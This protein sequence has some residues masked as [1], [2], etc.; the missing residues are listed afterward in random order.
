[1]SVDSIDAAAVSRSRTGVLVWVA[2]DGSSRSEAMDGI[3]A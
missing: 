3:N 1:M 2:R